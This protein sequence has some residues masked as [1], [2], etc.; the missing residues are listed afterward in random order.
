MF[1]QSLQRGL[2]TGF[3]ID[4]LII[5]NQHRSANIL[6]QFATGTAG[7]GVLQL[8]WQ[9]LFQIFLPAACINNCSCHVSGY[10]I[11]G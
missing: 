10:A 2:S 6:Q 1:S 11:P 3:H 7:K 9:K 4:D 8:P 5:E